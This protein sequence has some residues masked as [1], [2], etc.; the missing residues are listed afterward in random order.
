MTHGARN[1]LGGG[2]QGRLR[3]V[4]I[5]FVAAG[6]WWAARNALVLSMAR[7][8]VGAPTRAELIA[9][10]VTRLHPD[11]PLITSDF[12]EWQ[13]TSG[14]HPSPGVAWLAPDAKGEPRRHVFAGG[15]LSFRGYFTSAW[16][17]G[18]LGFR[19]YFMSAWVEADPACDKDGDGRLEVLQPVAVSHPVTVPPSAAADRWHEWGVVRLGQR[20]EL[21]QLVAVILLRSDDGG[22]YDVRWRDWD[23][24]GVDELVVSRTPSRRLQSAG[25]V[26]AVFGWTGPGGVLR[27]EQPSSDENVQLWLP[28]PCPY[29]FS[30]DLDLATFTFR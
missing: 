23:G 10:A 18:S 29:P 6:A 12:R 16:G 5:V 25:N 22:Y 8:S 13:L 7:G 9:A 4:V 27:A 3:V 30:P 1:N 21:N 14:L 24:D 11:F 2:A 15:D 17:T 28:Q 26:V 19:G 20:G